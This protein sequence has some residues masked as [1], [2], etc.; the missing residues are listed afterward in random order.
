MDDDREKAM[1]RPGGEM[2]QTKEHTKLLQTSHNLAGKCCTQKNTQSC[3]ILELPT[4]HK[5]DFLEMKNF[6]C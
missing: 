4:I 1:I 6:G 3:Y 2:L 5:A